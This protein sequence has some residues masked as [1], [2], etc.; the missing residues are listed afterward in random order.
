M[1]KQSL[2][3]KGETLA[4]KYLERQGFKIIERNARIGHKE[5]DLIASHG[6]TLVF[7]EVKTRASD[8]YGEASE[9]ITESKIRNIQEALAAYWQKHEGKFKDA[10]ID[11]IAINVHNHKAKLQH[12]KNVSM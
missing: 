9:A 11:V 5:V 6:R 2:G 8:T 12:Y 1:H 3:Q 10:R 4:A 7:I